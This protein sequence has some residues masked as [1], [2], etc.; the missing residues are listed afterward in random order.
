M[1]SKQR[2]SAMLL[3]LV[4]AIPVAASGR[5]STQLHNTTEAS[6]QEVR[7]HNEMERW[8]VTRLEE[9]RKLTHRC[10][11]SSRSA[12]A[13]GAGAPGPGHLHNS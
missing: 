2:R 3:R 8:V 7:G 1:A 12:T 9:R 13:C 10:F 6:T 4:K 5:L 11:R